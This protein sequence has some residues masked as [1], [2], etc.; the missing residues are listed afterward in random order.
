M[1]RIVFIGRA[2]R[3]SPH[4]VD[5]D[6][7]ILAAVRSRLEQDGFFCEDIMNE[8]QMTSLPQGDAYV[9]MGRDD[10]TVALL[11]CLKQLPVVNSAES[12][13]WTTARRSM[14]RQL[15]REG[16][17]VPPHR[18]NDGYWVKRG[19]GTAESEADVVYVP[20]LQDVEDAVRIMRQRGLRPEVRAHVV[21]DLVK[22]YAVK[23]TAFFRYYYPGDDGEWKFGSEEHNGKPRHTPFDLAM[24][25]AMLDKAAGIVG[26]EVYGG[27]CII[28]PDGRPVLVDLND[29]PSFS[30]CRDE[31]A[32]AIAERIKQRLERG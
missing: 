4:C 22:C 7:A 12:V 1:R 23:G 31:A 28:R 15:E 10:H 11:S 2:P 29:W 13:V 19:Y 32:V 20:T 18:G 3:Y 16:I 5:K 30:R 17:P 6:A 14:M 24:L 21:G 25:Q 9:T 26:L 8:E 27:D